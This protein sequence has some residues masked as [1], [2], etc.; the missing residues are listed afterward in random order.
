MEGRNEERKERERKRREGRGRWE[1]GRG[2]GE[3]KK[4][5]CWERRME[6]Q[7][8]GQSKKYQSLASFSIYSGKLMA[9]LQIC[10][11]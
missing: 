5:E 8:E 11:A 1:G 4:K 9:D 6:G 3:W 7:R 10:F 2:E